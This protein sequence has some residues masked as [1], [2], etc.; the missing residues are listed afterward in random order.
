MKKS[1]RRTNSASKRMSRVSSKNTDIELVVQ[2]QLREM[3]EAFRLHVD[4]LPGCP[5][6][7]IDSRRLAI[8]VNGCFWHGHKRCRK[9]RNMP[10]TNREFWLNKIAYNRQRDAAACR[11]LRAANWQPIVLWE[12]QVRDRGI[13]ERRIQQALWRTAP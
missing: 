13:L 5:D 9:G 6:I 12:C 10:G 3:G 4:D 7:V 2:E 8:F 1:S 11:S